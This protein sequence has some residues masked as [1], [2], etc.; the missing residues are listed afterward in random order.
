MHFRVFWSRQGTPAVEATLLWQD[1]KTTEGVTFLLARRE[2]FLHIRHLRP[3]S[4]IPENFWRHGTHLEMSIPQSTTTS[5]PWSYQEMERVEQFSSPPLAPWKK[6][7]IQLGLIDATTHQWQPTIIA[8]YA[9][10]GL[11]IV[12]LILSAT[13]KL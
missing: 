9:G 11:F 2:D 3:G 4:A 5:G 12:L 7:G 13:R 8:L 10:I 6:W 1:G